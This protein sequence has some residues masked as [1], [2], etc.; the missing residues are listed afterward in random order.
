MLDWISLKEFNEDVDKSKL[1]D[2]YKT[3]NYSKLFELVSNFEEFI[4]ERKINIILGSNSINAI[5]FY[6]ACLNKEAIPLLLSQ[7]IK[8]NQLINYI[9]RFSPF[10][11]Y[12][13]GLLEIDNANHITYENSNLYF[14]KSNKKLTSK[15]PYLLLT[16]SGSTG[17]PKVVIISKKNLISN[18]ESIKQYLKINKQDKHITTLPMNYTYGLSCINTHL[19][20]GASIVLTNESIMSKNFWEI[21]KNNAPNTISG[22]PYTYEMICRLGFKSLPLDCIEKFTQAGGKLANKYLNII[23]N[24]VDTKKKDFYIMYGQ[25]EATARMSYLPPKYLMSKKG[26]IGIPI[27]KGSFIL[28]Y[29]K[30]YPDYQGHSVGELIYKGPNVTAGYSECFDDLEKNFIPKE[31]L[32]TGDLAYQDCDGFYFICGRI[33]R[34]AKISGLRISLD[35]IQNII[36]E[37]YKCAVT[38]NDSFINIYLESNAFEDPFDLVIKNLKELILENVNINPIILKFKFIEKIPVNDSNKI[39][40]GD[41][42]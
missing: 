32:E 28:S 5:A 35:D 20:A 29:K 9:N 12:S 18:T 38:S 27:P 16:T 1:V 10:S 17:N 22:V 11:I 3:V 19:S 26:S 25:T 39:V 31:T 30:K 6:L 24:Y 33:N 37:K 23:G 2:E 42:N 34:F 14:L 8:K 15:Y 4:E 7:N 40:Y 36:N 13:E 21:L 41:L